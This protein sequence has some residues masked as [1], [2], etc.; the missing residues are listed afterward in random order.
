VLE[1][2][3][4]FPDRA[5]YRGPARHGRLHPHEPRATRSCSAPGRQLR[6]ADP[7][8]QRDRT[9]G[10]QRLGDNWTIFAHIDGRDS[11]ARTRASIATTRQSDPG[12]SSLYDFPTNDPSYTAIGRTAVRL[13]GATSLPGR[14]RTGSAADSTGRIRYKCTDR[15]AE[16]WI[17]AVG[18]LNMSGQ[19]AH[20]RLRRIPFTEWRRDSSDASR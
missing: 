6:I 13:Q 2:V 5:T 15:T 18:D 8:L 10:R 19:T 7:R 20:R 16:L 3:Q 17:D 14:S 4:P 1:D 11:T 9:H 12:I